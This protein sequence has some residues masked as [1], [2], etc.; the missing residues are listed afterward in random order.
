MDLTAPT[1]AL[2]IPTLSPSASTMPTVV[3]P[4]AAD[5]LNPLAITPLLLTNTA[6]TTT[7]IIIPIM[8]PNA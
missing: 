5:G 4:M 1:T 7:A 3:K 8:S 2:D 6:D